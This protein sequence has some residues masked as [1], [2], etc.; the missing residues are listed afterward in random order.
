V[1]DEADGLGKAGAVH[2]LDALG[3]FNQHAAAAVGPD[4]GR[5]ALH[6]AGFGVRPGNHDGFA[7]GG[8]DE[9]FRRQHGVIAILFDDGV[10]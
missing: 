7:Q 2:C 3:C 1:G 9:G 8:F 4:L 10:R 6:L 5:Y